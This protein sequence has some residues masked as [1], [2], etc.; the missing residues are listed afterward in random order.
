MSTYRQPLGVVILV[1]SK[2]G[3]KRVVARNDKPGNVG[4]KLTAEVKN[5]EEEVKRADTDD[6]I[7]LGDTSLP[8]KLVQSWI[9]GELW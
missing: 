8:F 2:Q 7:C 9:F 4:Q 3:M 6:G 1:G 5:N